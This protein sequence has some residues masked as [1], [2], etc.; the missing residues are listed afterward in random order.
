MFLLLLSLRAYFV[1]D[2]TVRL[3][4]EAGLVMAF[5]LLSFFFRAPDFCFVF[6]NF[7]QT[8]E[9]VGIHRL[10]GLEPPFVAWVRVPFAYKT[11]ILAHIKRVF[12]ELTETIELILNR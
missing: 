11:L 9:F 10:A 7:G 5:E 4:G 1:S 8:L 6:L 12:E 3:Y 2:A